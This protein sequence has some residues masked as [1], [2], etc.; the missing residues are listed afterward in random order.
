M[1]DYKK[2]FIKSN[3]LLIG[4]VLLIMNAV[5]MAYS[6]RTSVDE[7]KTVM[8]QKI[9]PYNTIRNILKE[10]PGGEDAAPP[11]KPSGGEDAAPPEKPSGED[12]KENGEKPPKPKDDFDSMP[13]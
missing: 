9:E 7:L 8:Q 4:L 13:T 3:L 10:Q 1:K 2:S 12:D 6:Y 11:E 5:I